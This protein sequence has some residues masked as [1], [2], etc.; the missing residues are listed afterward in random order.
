VEALDER[1]LEL[2]AD[3]VELVGSVQRD[4]P[5]AGVGRIGDERVA[6][7]SGTKT[8]TRGSGPTSRVA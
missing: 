5:D 2:G 1:L 4:D 7:G 6:L 3:G 8:D